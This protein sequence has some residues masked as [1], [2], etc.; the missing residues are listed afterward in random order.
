MRRWIFVVGLAGAS[1]SGTSAAV[2]QPVLVEPVLVETEG[3]AEIV[4]GDRVI[5]ERMAARNARR[6]AL[7]D[8][9][10]QVLSSDEERRRFDAKERLLTRELESA[11]T[12]LDA[13]HTE[14]DAGGG[15]IRIH[16]VA[17]FDA[18]RLRRALV[19]AGV[20]DAPKGKSQRVI[21]VVSDEISGVFA[22]ADLSESLGQAESTLIELLRREGYVVIDT[23]QSKKKLARERAVQELAGNEEAA[24]ALALEHGA[25]VLITGRAVAKPSGVRIGQ[26]KSVVAEVGLK[27]VELATA[28]TAATAT[29]SGTKAHIDEVAGGRKAIEDA[30]KAAGAKLLAELRAERAGDRRS[31]IELTLCGASQY[32]LALVKAELRK[33]FPELRSIAQRS[34]TSGVAKL[35]LELEAESSFEDFTDRLAL[36][37]FGEFRVRIDAA[38]AGTIE[39]TVLVRGVA[40]SEAKASGS[41]APAASAAPAAPDAPEAPD[42]E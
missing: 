27:A 29:G 7:R 33:A 16:A 24:I 9:A 4:G 10:L 28:T 31:S 38:S 23:D 41:N 40:A 20:L 17:S 22:R 37:D 39:A 6:S 42:R 13:Y 19:E 36:Q 8:A 1:I 5:A 11:L 15:S 32:Q 18:D 35:D 2:A 3:E 26:L 34:F 25:D 30:T 14:V 21:V 12:E